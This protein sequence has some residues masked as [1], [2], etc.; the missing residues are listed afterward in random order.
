MLTCQLFIVLHLWCILSYF[1][2]SLLL[3]SCSCVACSVLCSV[4]C[5]VAVCC[6]VLCVVLCCCVVVVV[7]WCVCGVVCGC[8]CGVCVGVCG[9]VCGGCVV[10]VVC[11]CGVLCCVVLC[12][13]CVCVCY[14]VCVVCVC[15]VCVV[16]VVCC[17]DGRGGGCGGGGGRRKGET[18]RT[19]SQLTP[20]KVSFKIAETEQLYQVKRMIGGAGTCCSRR[21]SLV[22]LWGQVITLRGLFLVSRTG[23]DPVCVESKRP[24]VY[25]QNVPVYAGTTPT[26]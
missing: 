5:C 16:C 6:S 25:I 1:A 23:D 3:F 7:V 22:N 15:V 10:C 12:V 2:S 17:C 14:V 21:V 24:R 26:C 13:L 19:I 11:V 8:V 18:N 4:L 20:A 9:C